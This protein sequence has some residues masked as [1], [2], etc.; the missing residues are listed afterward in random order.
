MIQFKITQDKVY[1]ENNQYV[2]PSLTIVMDRMRYNVDP[3]EIIKWIKEGNALF[4][5]AKS[6]S[7]G[8][9]VN[10]LN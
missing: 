1:N 8:T 9:H 7:N 10:I 5:Y 4:P 6:A 2:M 3:E